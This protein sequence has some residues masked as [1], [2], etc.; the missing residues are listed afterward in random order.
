MQH[1]I[2]LV[3]LAPV[4]LLLVLAQDATAVFGTAP[5]DAPWLERNCPVDTIVVMGA[6]QYDGRPSPAL[7]RRLEGALALYRA[8]C[9]ER[10]LVTGGRRE[11]DRFSEG[12]AGAAWLRSR[13]LPAH[14]VETEEE[15]R[16]TVENLRNVAPRLE[17]VRAAIVTDDLHAHRTAAVASRLGLDVV[18]A[19]V[20]V[21][22]GRTSYAVREIGALLSYRLGVFR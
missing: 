10:V 8:G 2:H 5:M 1:P 22:F 4:F 12:E 11:G 9:A 15:S 21:P 14:A 3:W 19:S 18:M 16:T 20:R 13:G 17:G 6:A 7:E